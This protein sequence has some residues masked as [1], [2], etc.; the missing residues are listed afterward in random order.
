VTRWFEPML[1]AAVLVAACCVTAD[2]P[3][4]A[5]PPPASEDDWTRVPGATWTA[6][7]PETAGYSSARLDSLRSW[8]KTLD[9]KAMLIAVHGQVIF[10]YGDVAHAS[11]VA[12]VRKSVLSMLY[13]NYVVKGVID[14]RKTV[15]D[16][17]LQEAEPFL[18]N[19]ERATLEH[20]ITARSG[21][22]LKSGN[23]GLDAVA[24]KRGAEFPGTRMQYNNWDFNAAGTAFEKLTGKTIYQALEQDLAR[25]LGMQDYDPARQGKVPS[26]GSVHPEYVMRLSTRDLAR[27]GL[28]MSRQGR[29]RD[30]QVVPAD[31]VRYTTTLVTPFARVHPTGLSV[32][33]Q[34]DRWGYGVM[35]WVWEEPTFPGGVST[36]PLQGA[37]TAMGAGGQYVTVLPAEDMVVAHT[38]DIDANG[39]ADVPTMAYDAILAMA[40]MSRCQS[41]ERC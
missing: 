3:A 24:P 6:V 27:L 35:W 41:R 13:G 21:I 26:P 9:T 10:E 15:K 18:P 1:T 29:W 37:Y 30:A 14:L 16:L 12:S 36:G 23:D 38:V 11:K 19:E 20:L 8:L 22:Y 4:A 25:P 31:W 39:R 40:I 5:Q 32:A 2:R 33:G 7:K 28:L 17:G 34:P